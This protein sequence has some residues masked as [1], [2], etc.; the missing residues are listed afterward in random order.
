MNWNMVV[1]VNPFAR[2]T[3]LMGQR[4]D[5]LTAISSNRMGRPA[6]RVRP[7]Y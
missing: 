7:R 2:Q 5:R 3:S 6:H 1:A 4:R